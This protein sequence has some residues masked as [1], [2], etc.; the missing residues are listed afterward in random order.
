MKTFAACLITFWFS[1]SP[2][3]YGNDSGL[4][5]DTPKPVN[6]LI[7]TEAPDFTL[8][9][10]DNNSI[11]LSALRGYYIVIHFATTWCPFC[12]AEA[13]YLE[14]IANDYKDKK[15]KVLVIDVKEHA[16]LVKARLRDRF[17]WS[18]PVLLDTEGK[19]AAAYAPE[20]LLPDLA[21]DEV[22]IA[23]N[24]LIDPE[25]KIRFMSLLDSR[26]FDA[27]LINLKSKLNELLSGN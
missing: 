3:C 27:Q 15:V 8:N 24:M 17:N 23:S 2:L 22:M 20:E 12:N 6:G 26:N 18:F 25:G 13:P 21:R 19:V 14:N 4:G 10:L 11:T 5:K 7:G 9:D 1:L 16:D